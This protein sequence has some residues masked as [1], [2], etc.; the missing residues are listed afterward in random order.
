MTGITRRS[1]LRGAA[2]TGLLAATGAAVAACQRPLL[3]APAERKP[4]RLGFLALTTADDYAPYTSAFRAGLHELGYAEGRNIVIEERFAQGHEDLLVGLAMAL[5]RSGVDVL[6]TASTQ[7]AL[8]AIAVTSNTPTVFFNS[9]DPLG[10]GLVSG[11]ARP[12]GNATGLTSLN[13]ELAGKRLELLKTAAPNVTR[14]AALWAD[15]AE[16]DVNETRASAFWLGMQVETFRVAG[17]NDLDNCLQQVAAYAP[18]GLVAIS[19]PLINSFTDRITDF[20]N[21]LR[22]ASISELSGFAERG[23]L[24]AYGANLV[25]LA[26]RAATYVDK[27]LAGARPSELPVERAERFELAVNLRAAQRLGLILPPPLLLQATQV[28]A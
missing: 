15:A 10:S 24:L 1:L 20:T 14:V 22:L 9:G 6:V 26:R 17:P 28:V 11:L 7:A 4:A 21:D 27:I 18:Q 3:T 23:G 16:R 5:V 12:G 8:A 19:S 2:A 13:R 25:E